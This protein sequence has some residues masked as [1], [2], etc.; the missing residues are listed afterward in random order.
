M[1]KDVD[2][3]QRDEENPRWDKEHFDKAKPAQDVLPKEFFEEMKRAR[4]KRQ[5]E[6]PLE[7]D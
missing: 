4:K 1:N 7:P 3:L 6:K 5:E 2:F